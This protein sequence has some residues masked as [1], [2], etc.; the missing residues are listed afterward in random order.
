[1]KKI[2]FSMIIAMIAAGTNLSA[3]NQQDRFLV[4]QSENNCK[5]MATLLNPNMDKYLY[6]ANIVTNFRN[7]KRQISTGIRFGNG[8][9]IYCLSDVNDAIY[10]GGIKLV[11]V[12]AE[13]NGKVSE[14]KFK[15]RKLNKGDKSTGLYK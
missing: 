8:E 15:W 3:M 1:M 12:L 14:L 9:A 13:N 10:F 7:G 11:K 2:I 4:L 5:N 6:N